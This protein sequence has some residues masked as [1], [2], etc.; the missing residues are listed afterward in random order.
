MTKLLINDWISNPSIQLISVITDDDSDRYYHDHNFFEIFYILDGSITHHLNGKKEVL[1][2]GDAFLLRPSD[3]HAFIRS[4][5]VPCAHRDIIISEQL[6]RKSC[7]FM[8]PDAFEKIINRKEPL[9]TRLTK[10]KIVDFEK[11]FSKMFFAPADQGFYTKKTMA[12]VLSVSLLNLFLQESQTDFDGLPIWLNNILPDFSS[13]ISMRIGLS[14][15]LKDIGYDKSYV[16]R[17]FKKYM[18]CTMT[19]YLRNQRID[20]ATSLLLTTDKS[21]PEICEEI[22]ID[23]VSYFITAFKQ[24]HS[25]SPKQFKRS[26]AISK[27][28]APSKHEKASSKQ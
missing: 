18:G 3:R 10:S 20:Y 13:P 16:C 8:D 7:D 17:T 11:E 2:T 4:P 12:N 5:G 26:F 9:K 25:L 23:S 14:L 6:L 28:N 24:R 19:E 22:G 21:I 15:I 27:K 1:Q